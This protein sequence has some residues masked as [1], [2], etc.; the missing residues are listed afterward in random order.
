MK[1]IGKNIWI[2]FLSIFFG[3]NHGICQNISGIVTNRSGNEL[4]FAT[5]YVKETGYGT[6]TNLDGNY[7]FSINPGEYIIIYQFL[8]YKTEYRNIT[9]ESE[10]IQVDVYL[11]EQS[12]VLPDLTYI[13]GEDPAYAIMRQVIAKSKYHL[14]Q[15][16]SPK[17]ISIE[18]SS[19][20]FMP[21]R[22]I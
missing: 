12:Y 5:I 1:V 11:E 2:L 18:L 20:Y 9:I 17:C 15:S 16:S 19:L 14:Y 7:E 21:N 10:S 8:G 22:I 4:P 13:S 6:T 3:T